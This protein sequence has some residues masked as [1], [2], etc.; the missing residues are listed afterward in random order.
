MFRQHTAEETELIQEGVRRGEGFK[1]I[2]RMLRARRGEFRGVAAEVMGGIN[3][4]AVEEAGD[5]PLS[6]SLSLSLSVCV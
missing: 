6:L 4:S 1:E 5:V 3:V 2:E